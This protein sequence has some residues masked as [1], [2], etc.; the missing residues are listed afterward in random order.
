M[1]LQNW[2]PMMKEAVNFF[3]FAFTKL[4]VLFIGISFLVGVINEFVSPERIKKILSGK[5]GRGYLVGAGLGGL[6]PFCSCS[7]IPITVGLLKARAGFG[8]TMAFLFA[9]PLVNP[10][11]V[12][13]FLAA[14]GLKVTGLYA[15]LALSMSMGVAYLLNGLGFEKHIRNDALGRTTETSCGCSSQEPS[16]EPCCASNSPVSQPATPFTSEAGASTGAACCTASSA[17]VASG[18]WARIFK[19]SLNQFRT[20]LPYIL[21]GIGI[22]ALLYGFVPGDFVIRYAGPEKP[23]AV[24]FAAIVGVPL[25]VRASTMVPIGISLIQKGMSLGAVLAL[26]I[27]GA[28]ASIPEVVMLKRIFKMPILVAFLASV[29]GIAVSAGYILN[30]LS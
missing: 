11:I 12:G 15:G 7:T 28:G 17:P 18:R 3:A 26:V 2:I 13:L 29:F 14:F 25:Y 5:R 22:G 10:V 4:M 27:G 1:D 6:T 16:V 24:P 8:P 20:F 19:E 30:L 21:V 23:L 9:S